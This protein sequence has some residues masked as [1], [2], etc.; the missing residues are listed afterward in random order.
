MHFCPL[1][2]LDATPLRLKLTSSL[3]I[4]ALL[5]E[6]LISVPSWCIECLLSSH[7]QFVYT[8]PMLILPV[9]HKGHVTLE[10][11]H[12]M[13]FMYNDLPLFMTLKPGRKGVF[14]MMRIQ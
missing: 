10:Y 11:H 5:C 6:L 12:D 8:N 1:V 9:F 13:C 7:Y 4:S 2:S 14:D 3:H